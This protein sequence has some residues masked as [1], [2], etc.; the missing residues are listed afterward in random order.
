MGI[1]ISV[2]SRLV[3]LFTLVG[4]LA[5]VFTGFFIQ[6]WMSLDWPV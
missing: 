6:I 5:G 2:D 3:R 4:G 1:D